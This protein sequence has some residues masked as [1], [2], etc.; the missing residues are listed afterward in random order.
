MASRF[1]LLTQRIILFF[2]ILTV[3]CYLVVC[4]LAYADAGNWWLVT[5]LVLLFP[6]LV[7]MLIIF[8]IFWLFQKKK[9]A[10]I[11]LLLLMAGW[12]SVTVLFAFHPPAVFHQEKNAGVLRVVTWNVA[13]FIE[14]KRN[15][16]QGS[17]IRAQMMEQLQQ[18]Q[19]DV[20]CLQEFFTSNNPGYYN[21]IRYIQQELGYPYYY[22]SYDE[23]GKNSFYS[24][25]IFSRLPIVD[26]EK[27]YFPRPGLSEALLRADVKFNGDTVSIFTTHLQSV[28]FRKTDYDKI[29][30]IQTGQDSLLQ[31]SKAILAKLKLAAAYRHQQARVVQQTMQKCPHPKIF[32][33][34]LN[35]VPASY[36]YF[37]VRSGMRDAFL[38]RGTGLGRTFAGISPTL[39]ID[40][41]FTD[42]RFTVQ[43]FNRVVKKLS[44]HYM[45]VADLQLA[46]E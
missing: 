13:R 40:Y 22:F 8:L 36:T 33:G 25:V 2:T 14:L 11:V 10:L 1:R 44:D 26:T 23:D 39:R 32:M 12:K 20:L 35:D 29:E 38:E 30:K 41:V 21:N 19:A 15:D 17:K 46:Q 43:Q 7:L 28:Q 3:V 27:L 24:S 16:N 9:I 34:D 42:P 4:L 31:N 18:Q 45:L 5:A 6:L 37:T